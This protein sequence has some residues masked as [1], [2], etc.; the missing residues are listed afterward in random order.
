MMLG[1]FQRGHV[2]SILT[3]GIYIPNLN[4][5]SYSYMNVMLYL[6]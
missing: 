5:Q 6:L 3:P 4:I 2:L 1:Q